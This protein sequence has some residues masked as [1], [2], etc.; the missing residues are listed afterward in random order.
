[1]PDNLAII[2]GSFPPMRCGVGDYTYNISQAFAVR[3]VRVHIYTSAGLDF[4]RCPLLGVIIRPQFSGW[5]LVDV[6]K[7]FPEFLR[8]LVLNKV[9]WINIQYPAIGYG[10]K[11]GPQ[12]LICLLRL[13]SCIKVVSTIHEFTRAR[14]LRKVSLIP[15]ILFSTK[16]VFTAQAEVEAVR[17]W[18]PIRLLGGVPEAVV[19]P[20]GS[21]IPVV[22]YRP[23][24]KHKSFVVFFGL[25]YPGRQL[26]L[27]AETY[28]KI[29][30]ARTDVVFGI[31][32]DVHPRQRDYYKALRAN[33]DSAIPSG[34][35]EW[36]IGESPDAIA[37]ILAS[38]SAALLPYPD[39]ASFRRTTLMA[40]I[41]SGVP[42]VS[43]WGDDTPAALR[44]G[45]NILFG[46]DAGSLAD[47][48]L[49]LL[50]DK[51]ISDRIAAGGL[52][53]AKDFSWEKISA[54]YLD[55]LSHGDGALP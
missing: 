30:A 5:G 51:T 42:V 19:I 39:G 2:C 9:D 24:T 16:L 36:H 10:Y 31:I 1:M 21:N 3:G 34:R 43:T 23:E 26:E 55:F 44:E 27:V 53:L 32:G 54:A 15:F 37:S 49:L 14:V 35:L 50:S 8:E 13:F 41:K 29:Y 45:E 40:A 52:A 48:I 22:E 11:M 47:K 17:K 6:A 28:K 46:S 25:F 38:A 12:L 18:L 33:F 4:D 7:F 20:V